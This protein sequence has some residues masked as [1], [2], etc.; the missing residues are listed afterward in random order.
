MKS[1][2]IGLTCLLVLLL[3]AAWYTTPARLQPASQQLTLQ[4]V[5][6]A[7][8]LEG[9][10]ADTEAVTQAAYGIVE[11]AEKRIVWAEDS[12]QKTEF[13]VVNLHGFSA[14]RQEIAPVPER[15]AAALGANLFETRLS[16]HGQLREAMENVPAEAWLADGV[17]ALAIGRLLGEKIILMGTSTGATIALAMAKHPD[18][19]AVDSLIFLSP[20]FGPAAAGSDIATMPFGPQITRLVAGAIHQWEPANELQGKY[21]TTRYPIETI[22][23]M[24][25]LVKHAVPI[26]TEMRVN[27][28]L[29]M[30]SPK[31]DVVS[32]DKLLTGFESMSAARKHIVRIDEP[33]SISPHVF[34]GNILG[35]EAVEESVASIVGFL[36][37]AP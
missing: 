8:D 4:G 24:M 32:V 2:L 30:Y 29:L 17:E 5:T 22:V 26:A 28:A 11:E 36:N 3:V 31:D 33:K 35:P 20:N 16:G 7:A 21:W 23:E 1:V 9:Y 25:R 13:V 15:V 12:G 27:N 6:S 37:G 19:S 18:F 14:T 10:L 34:T